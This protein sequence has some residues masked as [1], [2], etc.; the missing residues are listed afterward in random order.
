MVKLQPVRGRREG[1]L[2]AVRLVAARQELHVHGIRVSQSRRG[3]SVEMSLEMDDTLSLE[4]AHEAATRFEQALREETPTLERIITRLEP[5][6]ERSTAVAALESD[7]EPVARAPDSIRRELAWVVR[8]RDLTIRRA[9]EHLS[10]SVHCAVGTLASLSEADRL[11]QEIER[12]LRGRVPQL[13]R[14]MIHLEPL[15]R[16]ARVEARDVPAVE[17]ASSPGLVPSSFGV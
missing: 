5:V 4:V 3:P 7:E 9:G 10:A 11:A 12:R 15:A 13:D 16:L 8:F 17:E 6:R 14:V 1:I 2:D